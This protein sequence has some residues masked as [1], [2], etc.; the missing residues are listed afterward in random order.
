MKFI[1]VVLIFLVINGDAFAMK[2][3]MKIATF[4]I[5]R[6]PE[7]FGTTRGQERVKKICE[8]LKDESHPEHG[9]WDILLLQEVW[10]KK[11]RKRLKRCGYEYSMDV[12]NKLS[13]REGGLDSGLVILSKYPIIE[14]H[15]LVFNTQGPLHRALIDGEALVD[16]SVYLAKIVHPSGES[17]WVANTHLIANYLEADKGTDEK[18]KRDYRKEREEQFIQMSHW[19]K[20]KTKDEPLIL[21]GD[22]NMGDHPRLRDNVWNNFQN[23]FQNFKQAEHDR[24]EVS[25]TSPENYFRTARNEEGKVDH[26]FASEHFE[27]HSGAVVFN[28]KFESKRGK[29]IN[30]SDH[31][32][33]ESIVSLRPSFIKVR[34][35]NLASAGAQ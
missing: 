5:F 25:T 9:S 35:A 27:I 13:G 1:V 10:V 31:Y 28:Q 19:L 26:L 3:N 4:N 15:R 29:I 2:S 16:K 34:S 7:I 18:R 11:A 6:L 12:N 17:I 8:I 14:K 32:A 23:Y 33:W 24:A 20:S 30:Y 22:L 21:G